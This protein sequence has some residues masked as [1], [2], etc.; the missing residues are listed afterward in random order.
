MN[1]PAEL[2][3]VIQAGGYNEQQIYN[4]DEGGVYW[5]LLPSKSQ[6]AREDPQKEGYIQRKDRV[7]LLFTANKTGKHNCCH[8]S[9][10]SKNPRCFHNVNLLNLPVVYEASKNAWMT[11][12]IFKSFMPQTRLFLQCKNLEE[13]AILLLD[14][15]PAHLHA[16]ELTTNDGKI[17]VVYLQGNTTSK[18]QP[19]D[20]EVISTFKTHYHRELLCKVLVNEWFTLQEPIKALTVKDLVYIAAH[21]WGRIRA[22][23]IVKCWMKGLGG[24]FEQDVTPTCA[25]TEDIENA[26]VAGLGETMTNVSDDFVGA[27][28]WI[29]FNDDCEGFET[30]SDD[31]IIAKQTE[32]G[33]ENDTDED[34]TDEVAVPN[35]SKVLQ[36]LQTA[37]QFLE[38][39]DGSEVDTIQLMQIHIMM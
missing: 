32:P 33:A 7:T 1:Y 28:T 13:K 30:L 15:C 35:A 17:K 36:G 6:Y 8:F 2:K 19:I 3:E 12:Q 21:C 26:A 20:Q 34:D 5:K 27:N 16:N 24:A 31:D 14:T 25:D 9:S 29:H 23:S 39:C 37:L 11:S 10:K 4:A 18:I 22:E 38:S